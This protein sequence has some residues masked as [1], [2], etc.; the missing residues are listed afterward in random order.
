[1]SLPVIINPLAEADLKTGYAWCEQRRPGQG[2]D[3]LLCA[4]EVF[5]RIGR[6]PE[7]Y[8][9]EFEELRVAPLRRHPYG[10]VYRID[11][12]QITVVAVYHLRSNPRVWQSRA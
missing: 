6:Q 12:A 9:R 7:W 1:V 11:A 5:E 2:A 10:V 8:G 3:F 4:E